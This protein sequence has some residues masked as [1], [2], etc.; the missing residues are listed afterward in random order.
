MTSYPLHSHKHCEIMLYLSG[1]GELRTDAQPVPFGKGTI[2]IVPGGIRHGSVSHDGFCNISIEGAFERY[3][4]LDGIRVLKDNASQEGAALARLIW[5]NR[6]RRDEYL[7]ALLQAYVHYL[8]QHITAESSLQSAVERVAAAI[9]EC[10]FEMHAQP[11]RILATSGY[12]EDYIRACFTRIMGMTPTAYLTDVRIRHACFLMDVYRD[13]LPLSEIARRCG[14]ADYVH[15]S[16][17]FKSRMGM[18][19]RQYQ[20]R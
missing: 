17:K 5:D 2:V 1:E 20:K 10:A 15:F 13:T 4:C 11:A 3:F 12:S 6:F 9:E 16:K 18:S 14:Y 7:N 8:M 19:P